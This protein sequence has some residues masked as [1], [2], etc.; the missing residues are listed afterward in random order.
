MKSCL[1][2]VSLDNWTIENEGLLS[3]LSEQEVRA[4]RLHG[5]KRELLSSLVGY[6]LA[7]SLIR[8]RYHAEGELKRERGGKPYLD[9]PDWEGDFSMSHSENLVVCAI[10]P[11][12]KIGV[13]VEKA[14]PVMNELIR[15]CLSEQERKQWMDASN[16][17]ERKALF[18]RFWTLKEAYLKFT[19]AGL[20]GASLPELDF[21]GK[22]QTQAVSAPD[23][24]EDGSYPVLLHNEK[25]Q[26][27]VKFCHFELA[28]GYSLAS[29]GD[30]RF[31]A[32]EWLSS[33]RLLPSKPIHASRKLVRETGF[34]KV[35]GLWSSF[36]S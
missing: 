13:D 18:F 30:E 9:S 34:R 24:R 22:A 10:T 7:K 6:T 23:A 29:C 4:L 8:F 1:V 21:A 28:G 12:G 27:E 2:A 17:E 31:S 19:G 5:T 3:L 35:P 16:D 25:E 32:P 33:P 11:T 20:I 14:R 26:D 15:E 36:F